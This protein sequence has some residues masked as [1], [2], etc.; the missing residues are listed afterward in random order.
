MVVRGT[1]SRNS[2]ILRGRRAEV[3]CRVLVV[4]IRL[5]VLGIIIT[6][7]RFRRLIMTVVTLSRRGLSRM[8]LAPILVLVK[9]VSRS[10]LKVLL[11]MCFIT[12]AGVFSCVVV[13]V[14]PVFPFFGIARKLAFSRALLVRGSR[15]VR[16]IRLTPMSLKSQTTAVR[17]DP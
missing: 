9:S 17:G 1:L 7:P 5:P 16:Y 6:R 2:S 10:C 3:K 11:F 13:M 15:G 4:V 12:V 14:R 8:V